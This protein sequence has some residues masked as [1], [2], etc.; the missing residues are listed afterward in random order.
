MAL[1]WSA[2]GVEVHK[3][4]VRPLEGNLP[5][6]FPEDFDNNVFTIRCTETGEAMLIAG[7]LLLGIGCSVVLMGSLFLFGQ[8]A[9][10]AS[11]STWIVY[12]VLIAYRLSEGLRGRRAA[13]MSILGFIL[14]LATFFG[15]RS[16][17]SAHTFY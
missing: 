2:T 1:H 14:I 9:P 4:V 7:R 3:H 16:Q 11:F 15:T 13:W 8:W 12:A 10:A 6:G 5:H 17:G